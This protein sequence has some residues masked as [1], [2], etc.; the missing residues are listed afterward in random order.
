MSAAHKT[1]LVMA[2]GTG[3]HV[4]PA[5]ACADVLREQGVNVEWLGTAAGIEARV[6]PDADIKLHCIDVTGLRGKGKLSLL[7]APFKLVKACYQALKVLR[8]VKPDAVLGMGGFASGPGGAAAY[9]TGVPVI[10]H[11]QNAA[12]GL[13]NKLLS[14]VASVVMEAFGGAFN[15]N[16]KTQVVGNPVRGNILQLAEPEVRFAQRNGAIRLL[17]VGGSLGAQAINT[18]LP[19]V[20]KELPESQFEV[21]H[22]A[23]R[24][25]IEATE[26]AYDA[27]GLNG[28]DNIRVVDF[29]DRM[30]EAYGWADIVLCR[31]GA[32]TVS[33]L[34]IA[35]AAAILVPF[36]HAVDDHQ[37]GNARY[38][39]E[40]GAAVLVQQG[41]LD[42]ARL[43]TL[44]TDEL[45]Q[46]DTL[47]EM[48]QAAKSLG[49]PEATEIVANA[50]LEEMK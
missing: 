41:D 42:K 24:R 25:N 4:F 20:L 7:L 8:R 36:P 30:D 21:L 46:R 10:V 35:G 3:G 19:Q 31:A 22:Q 16:L 39:S 5:L 38:L 1:L 49:R 9:L 15:S 28:R 6:V 48:A 13:T 40:Q 17:V 47:L 44:L 34:S 27:A 50:C 18:L 37:T 43:K 29:I 11:E 2:G 14:K 32:L 12:A 23:G 45:S 33:E 26:Q